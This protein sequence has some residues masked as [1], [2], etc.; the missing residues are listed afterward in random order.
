[1]PAGTIPVWDALIRMVVALI[2]GT[3]IGIERELHG[4]PAGMRTQALVSLG[5]ALFTMLSASIADSRS[6]PGRI[7]AQIVTGV[8]F[9]GAGTIMRYGATV[10]GL[11][12]AATIWAAAAVGMACGMGDYPV[13][14][15]ASALIIITV[16]LFRPVAYMTR[17]HKP[18]SFILVTATA[19]LLTELED[20]CRKLGI[21]LS[22]MEVRPASHED[23][24][25][26]LLKVELPPHVPAE[27][28]AA[29]LQ[30]IEGVREVKV[31][32]A[33]PPSRAGWAGKMRFTSRRD[34]SGRWG[35]PRKPL[36]P[37]AP[38]R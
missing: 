2:L 29:A 16:G 30:A 9:L 24:Q 10:R 34:G 1:M 28:V 37:A 35:H 6:D 5:A 27:K 7:A 3:L 25:S 15:I 22:G 4:R 8:G 17:P 38:A 36:P 31:T 23:S 13:A 19:P 32:Q 14:F 21:K 11:T 12:T 20:A 33:E 18:H 26:L